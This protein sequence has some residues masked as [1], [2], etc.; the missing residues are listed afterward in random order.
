MW[1]SDTIDC[2][3]EKVLLPD[4]VREFLSRLS[5]LGRIPLRILDEND[6][7]LAC[8]PDNEAEALAAPPSGGVW[9]RADGEPGNAPAVP[10]REPLVR[11]ISFRDRPIG[12]IHGVPEPGSNPAQAHR[13]LELASSWIEGQM[14]AE[15]NTN[16]LSAEILNNY[17]ELNL[18]YEISQEIVSVFDPNEVCEIVLRKALSVIGA[19]K[20][21]I[22]L[23]DPGRKRLRLMAS[24]GL[25]AL[26]TEPL[27]LEPD[28]GICGYVFQSGKPLLVEEMAD[29]PG[30]LTRGCGTYQ[31]ESFLSVPMLVSPMKVKEKIIGLINLADKPAHRPYNAGDLKLLSAISS[32]AALS[33]HNS[34]L[35]KD[36]KENERFLKE[37]EIAE[38]LQ[39][40]LI[41]RESP[42]VPG[43]ELAGRCVPAKE[44]GGDYFD[45]FPCPD[46]SVGIVVADVSGHSI[47]SGIMMAITRGLLKSEGLHTQNPGRVLNDVNRILFSDLVSSELF[48]TM[49]YFSYQPA[50]RTLSFANGGHNPPVLLRSGREQ[51][52]WLDADGMGIGFMEDVTFEQKTCLLEPND[53]LVLYTDGIMEAENADQEQ[54]GMERFLG[55]LQSLRNRSSQE[56][57]DGLY[58]AVMSH[59]GGTH[60]LQ[61]QQDDITLVV[62]KVSEGSD[63]RPV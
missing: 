63:Q 59:M 12:K 36:L 41:P 48:I 32:Q 17:E 19:E 3:L 28:V 14:A 39:K 45:Y 58:R 8:V 42:R 51:A 22:F 27:Y 43:I 10:G 4:E 31:T 21:S 26:S 40:N 15:Y 11:E 46:G 25:P 29:L 2:S 62:L 7:V 18:L 50:Q 49:I 6:R 44:V 47:S 61:R 34:L 24:V 33:V 56:I 52:E 60:P 54:F 13:I 53:I 37:M 16:S 35:I 55:H 20:A 9:D 30:D 57:L 23:W 38:A 1:Q 5:R